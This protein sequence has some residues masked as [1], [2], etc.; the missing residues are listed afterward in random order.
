[1]GADFGIIPYADNKLSAFKRLTELK[2]S[3]LK[4][5]GLDYGSSAYE[6]ITSLLFILAR[7][8]NNMTPQD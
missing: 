6:L 8:Q 3:S 2:V 4:P 1:M 7:S 5:N